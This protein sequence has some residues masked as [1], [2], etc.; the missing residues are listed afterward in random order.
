MNENHIRHL[1]RTEQLRPLR[2][3]PSK[4]LS[5]LKAIE[6]N[7]AVILNIPLNNDTA[8]VIFRELYECI[9]QLG[10]A[11]WWEEGYEPRNH[12]VSLDILKSVPIPHRLALPH[13]QRFKAIRHDINYRGFQASEIQAQELVGFWRTSGVELL[14]HIR[15]GLS[16]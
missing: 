6:K 3:E 9:R 10:D 15:K 2:V 14:E 4:I 5:L 13:L 8:S 11:A 12:E 7:S 16:R 1:V